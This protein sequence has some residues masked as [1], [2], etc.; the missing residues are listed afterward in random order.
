[1]DDP[2]LDRRQSEFERP[3]AADYL[4]GNVVTYVGW[5]VLMFVSFI[6]II[7]WAWVITAWMRWICRNVAGTRR[8]IVFG[9]TGW[10]VLWRTVLFGLGGALLI[11]I[12]WVMR[13]YATWY[14]SRF[15][16]VERTAWAN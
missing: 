2:A 14:V 1:M 9:A 4:N 3:A 11:P 8:E 16:L 13:W 10:Q 15:A 12:P 7:G 6:T 5:Y